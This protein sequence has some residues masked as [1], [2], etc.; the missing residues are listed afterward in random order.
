[1]KQKPNVSDRGARSAGA[2]SAP[3]LRTANKVQS[4]GKRAA[5][6]SELAFHNRQ[7]RTDAAVRTIPGLHDFGN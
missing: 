1:M 6:D 3:P 2:E 7:A 5:A 4:S